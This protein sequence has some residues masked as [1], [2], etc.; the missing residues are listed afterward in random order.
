[1]KKFTF[2]LLAL[3][4]ALSAN[5]QRGPM[6]IS[7]YNQ[8]E[9]AEDLCGI[10]YW[11]YKYLTHEPTAN[12]DRVDEMSGYM[13]YNTL[14]A[15]AITLL[16]A[17][18]NTVQIWGMFEKPL[19]ATFSIVSGTPRLTVQAGQV[20]ETTKDGDNIVLKAAG[21]YNNAYTNAYGSFNLTATTNYLYTSYWL[22]PRNSTTGENVGKY[23]RYTSTRNDNYL[24]SAQQFN[25]DNYN[26][27]M[28][29][30][31]AK[32]LSNNVGVTYPVNITQIGNV[33]SIKN[34]MGRGGTVT[35]TLKADGT[36]EIP[37]QLAYVNGE[38]SY[39][40]WGADF[41]AGTNV[42][43]GK[44]IEG[45]GSERELSLGN[46]K[47]VSTPGNYWSG[48]I[49]SATIR[50]TKDNKFHFPIALMIS[51]AGIASF[52]SEKNVDFSQATKLGD[53]PETVAL[54]PNVV[55]DFTAQKATLEALDAPIPAN[56][57]VFVKGEAGDYEV[58]TVAEA[59]TPNI[60]N[61]L[62]ATSNQ[63]VQGDG[64]TIYAL[65]LKDGKPGVMLVTAGTTI[66]ANKAYL[67]GNFGS[68]AKFISFDGETTAIDG[69]EV[70]TDE[71]APA[72]NLQG[73]RVG[74][75][76]RGIVVK[77]GKKSVV[78]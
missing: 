10:Y 32:S 74:L 31:Y 40:T 78:R 66:A 27:I 63:E 18:D 35:I 68:G 37:Q 13:G 53:M 71:A 2:M 54:T 17:E 61:H 60:V 49:K 34:F 77:N 23:Y 33:V 5:A 41:S 25:D 67:E 75:N 14:N 72:Y 59:A 22:D 36:L 62:L 69:V 7:K 51:D 52:S 70:S 21:F 6:K 64:S 12:D 26:G 50:F 45:T 48:A 43:V 20:I 44:T 58:P 8:A 65:G 3:I 39:Y 9:K 30:E 11:G 24:Q 55:T 28:S 46:F 56:Y 15:A 16:S 42:T 29:I 1:M 76:Y 57:G 38:E 73:Q 4:A 19:T 47:L